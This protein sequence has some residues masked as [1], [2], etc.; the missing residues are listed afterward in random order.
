M[1]GLISPLTEVKGKSKASQGQ[2]KGR[3][4]EILKG[5]GHVKR[6]QRKLSR[7][8]GG[9][10]VD[11]PQAITKLPGYYRLANNFIGLS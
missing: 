11:L 10:L 7:I 4:S 5:K 3:L 8:R 2:V 9:N 6:R 1:E